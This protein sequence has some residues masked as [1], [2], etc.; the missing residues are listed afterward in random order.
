M[1]YWLTIAAYGVLAVPWMV[2]WIKEGDENLVP[3]L[4]VL[5]EGDVPENATQT[6]VLQWWD[7][8]VNWW[9]I[10]DDTPSFIRWY[11]R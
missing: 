3:L 6:E 2:K 1:S 7:Q 10:P 11:F 5:V 9:R 4:H 8:D